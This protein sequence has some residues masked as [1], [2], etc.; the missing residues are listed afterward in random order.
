MGVKGTCNLGTGIHQPYQTTRLAIYGVVM[1]CHSLRL[2]NQIS[3]IMLLSSPTRDA[4]NVSWGCWKI[5]VG[6]PRSWFI[7]EAQFCSKWLW[8]L[9]L[10]YHIWWMQGDKLPSWHTSNSK[11]L[12]Q[13]IQ[14]NLG[15]IWLRY[16]NKEHFPV[17]FIVL[18][19]ERHWDSQ[20]R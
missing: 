6:T 14:A 17:C 18:L 5:S 2:P 10:W 8:S 19:H 13:G 15:C 7:S 12:T 1:N 9:L 3:G 4:K 11:I 20:D 16:T